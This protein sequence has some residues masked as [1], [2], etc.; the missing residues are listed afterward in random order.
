MVGS[1]HELRC[2][3]ALT[4]IERYLDDEVEG[5]IRVRLERHL[6][7]CQGCLRHADFR[8]HLKVLISSKCVEHR[9]P[10]DLADRILSAIRDTDPA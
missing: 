8:R 4:Y 10:S 1:E 7:V 9:L 6:S 2:L 5:S 3:E